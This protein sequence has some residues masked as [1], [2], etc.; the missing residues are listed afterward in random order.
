MSI[1]NKALLE[2]CR[3][4]ILTDLSV[5]LLDDLIK[6]ALITSERE[7][8]QIDIAPLAWLTETYSELFTKP[9]AT[10]SA[11]TAANPGV[12]T[13]DSSDDDVTGH[14]F[15]TGDIILITGVGDMERLNN[16]LFRVVYVAATTFSLEQLDGENAINTTNYETYASGGTIYHA[17]ILIPHTSIEPSGTVASYD[18]KI[19]S[20]SGVTFDL[21][22][23]TP[24]SDQAVQA[25]PGYLLSGGRPSR[26][27]YWKHIYSDPTTIEH[28]LLFYGPAGQRYNIAL[29]IEKEYPDLN[30]WTEAVYPPH[31]A[32]VHDAIW[33]RA[34]WIMSTNAERSKRTTREGGQNTKAEILYAQMWQNKVVEDEIRIIN[35]SR[36]LNGSDARSASGGI[37]A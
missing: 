5:E 32:E 17:G 15:A 26:H 2:K 9:S 18:W 3:R 19:G 16:R 28:F 23:S 14:G 10:I 31:P 7:I 21:S 22:P 12:I 25:N 37:R 11:I 4:F 13:A 1:S 36:R 8:R 33:H 27:R 6:D 20:I 29:T 30:V 35:L 24:I 34:L